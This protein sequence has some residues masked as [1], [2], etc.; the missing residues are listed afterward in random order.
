MVNHNE[1]HLRFDRLFHH[2]NLQPSTDMKKYIAKL[3]ILTLCAAALLAV[4]ALSRAQNNAPAPATPPPP[5]APAPPPPAVTT[6]PPAVTPP[7]AASKPAVKRH[8]ASGSSFHGTLTA[9]DTN[10]MTLTVEKRTFAITSKTMITK[11]G[12]PAILA[13]GTVG[14]AVRGTYKK[15]AKGELDAVTVSLGGP[16]KGQSK[17]AAGN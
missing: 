15:T 3:P 7:A 13:D 10:A 11:D 16:A 14:D 12:K 9:V 8:T 4:P 2:K 5:A 17:G 6:L 1:I